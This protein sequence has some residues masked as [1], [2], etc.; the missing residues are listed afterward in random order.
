MHRTLFQQKKY[1][2]ELKNVERGKQFLQ[3][4]QRWNQTGLY[5]SIS[6]RNFIT[7]FLHL[8]TPHLQ[9]LNPKPPSIC[10]SISFF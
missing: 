4:A 5:S 3:L 1:T 2:D 10:S 9:L 6:K 7:F 8:Q